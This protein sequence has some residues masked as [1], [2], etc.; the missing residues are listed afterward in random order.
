M[1]VRMCIVCIMQIHICMI[2]YH[3][4]P[5]HFQSEDRPTGWWAFDRAWELGNLTAR[6]LRELEGGG[7]GFQTSCDLELCYLGSYWGLMAL[8]S[9]L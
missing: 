9:D 2:I 3:L 6:A 8:N 1:Y 4:R 5:S 7:G